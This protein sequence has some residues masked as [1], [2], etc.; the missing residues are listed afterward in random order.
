[1][2]K[3]STQST[4]AATPVPRSSVTQPQRQGIQRPPHP[5]PA[6][7]RSRRICSAVLAARARRRRPSHVPDSMPFFRMQASEAD[8]AKMDLAKR[9]QHRYV[10]QLRRE[11]SDLRQ[12]LRSVI[13]TAPHLFRNL[14]FAR[15][16]QMVSK[17]PPCPPPPFVFYRVMGGLAR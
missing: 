1:M 14:D 15:L 8:V 13:S 17:S 10:N 6:I 4:A 5:A 7:S 9:Q 12:E 11:N 2:V 3:H 16:Q